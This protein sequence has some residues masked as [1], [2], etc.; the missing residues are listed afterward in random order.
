MRQSINILYQTT[1]AS[2]KIRNA[3]TYLGICWYLLGP[4]LTFVVLL[5]VFSHR[6][7]ADIEHYPLYLLSGI[8]IWNFFSMGTS[9]SLTCVFGQAGLIKSLPVRRELLVLSTVLDV[10][11][12]HLFE[13]AVLFAIAAYYGVLSFT[14]VFIPIVLLLNFIFT[15]G[16]SYALAA[17]M[18][19]FRDLG[20]IWSIVTKVWWFATP[21][22][23]ALY[24][25][26]KGEKVSMFNPMF[27]VL[28]ISRDVLIYGTV[29][30]FKSLLILS[31]FSF[32]TL[33]I[34]ILIFRKLYPHFAEYV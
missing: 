2:F 9:R 27:H 5:L 3:N 25:G 18:F 6:L 32:A 34:G 7:G 19:V 13:I 30:G 33:F 31:A 14:V 15:L 23:Y 16:V 4:I 11:I 28:D 17:L 8:V 22:F 12:S 1:K 29:P 20:Q 24:E 21:I 26:G 10:L